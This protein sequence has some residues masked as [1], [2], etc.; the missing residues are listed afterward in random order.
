M[1]KYGLYLT[2]ETRE[3]GEKR[4]D[5]RSVEA[6]TIDAALAAFMIAGDEG[7][8]SNKPTDPNHDAAKRRFS[9]AGVSYRVQATKASTKA[10]NKESL[11]REVSVLSGM[12]AL[13]AKRAKLTAESLA[14]L[15]AEVE[16][17]IPA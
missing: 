16:K 6:E 2:N 15:R 8:P 10:P 13:L 3:V 1:T 9:H 12:V 4:S 11:S 14:T 7:K 5:F 17:A